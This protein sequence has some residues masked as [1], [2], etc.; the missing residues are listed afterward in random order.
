MEGLGSAA[1]AAG[2]G[3]ILARVNVEESAFVMARRL[4]FHMGWEE[5]LALGKLTRFWHD[6]QAEEIAECEA[7]D[8]AV[9]FKVEPKEAE[10]LLGVLVE[11]KTVIELGQ[12]RYRIR[13]NA[14]HIDALKQR[15]D[16]AAQGGRKSGMVRSG[17][18]PKK[19]T[20]D[21]AHA[22]T[23]ASTKPEVS[24]EA[25]GEPRTEQSRAEQN[26]S[27][28]PPRVGGAIGEQ[29]SECVEQWGRTLRHWKNP[30]NAKLDEYEIGGLI[31]SLG[32]ETVRMALAGFRG[33]KKS[34]DFDP[35]QHLTF[36]R[37]RAKDKRERLVNLGAAVLEADARAAP[38]YIEN[39][40]DDL[41]SGR[42]K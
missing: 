14:K 8:I 22:S 19:N 31:Q 28:K 11:A 27:P 23:H 35:A 34:A 17:I 30:K 18:I 15:K 13:G 42:A 40:W 3:D 2:L 4:S 39:S 9:W 12:G 25:S 26:I 36:G 24:L 21:E 16:A 29:I 5:D 38:G 7:A 32:F 10:R 33:E 37:I 20:D 41:I 1:G 6:S